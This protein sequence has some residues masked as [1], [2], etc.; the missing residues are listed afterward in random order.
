VSATVYSVS[1]LARLL[2]TTP[3]RVRGLVRDGV[4]T[5]DRGPR[6]ELQLSFRDVLLLRT[7]VELSRRLPAARVK[8][9]LRHVRGRLAPERALSTLRIVADGDDVVVHDGPASFVAESGQLLLE[10]DVDAALGEIAALGAG[11][12]VAAQ[13][14]AQA[15]TLEASDRGAAIAAYRRALAADPGHVPALVNL[16]RMLHDHGASREAASLY[17]RALESDPEDATALFN[18]GVALE[19]LGRLLY[20]RRCYEHALRLEASHVDAHFNLARLCERL[21]DRAAAMRHLSRYRALTR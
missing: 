1:R 3:A 20:A 4:V 10:L 8:R 11:A 14:V 12:G 18:L 19:D 21:G 9:A 2:H 16:G 17:V 7:A 5:P 6:G 13:W 15:A